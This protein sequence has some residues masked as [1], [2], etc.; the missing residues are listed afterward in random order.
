MEL[1]DID[2]L[3]K[4]EGSG[5]FYDLFQIF[6]KKDN[7]KFIK[8]FLILI[9]NSYNIIIYLEIIMGS[10]KKQRKKKMNKHKLDKRRRNR[11]KK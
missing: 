10:V 9:N 6:F 4:N 5:D 1:Y 3:V 2:N 7:M 11:N 8:Q